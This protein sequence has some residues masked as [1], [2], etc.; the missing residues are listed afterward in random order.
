MLVNSL[1]LV[2]KNRGAGDPH[3]NPA[4]FPASLALPSEINV[5]WDVCHVLVPSRHLVTVSDS[6]C[7]NSFT[8]QQRLPCSRTP[9]GKIRLS[10]ATQAPS[11]PARSQAALTPRLHRL[12]RRKAAAPPRAIYNPPV[13]RHLPRPPQDRR[14]DW[15]PSGRD[16]TGAMPRW[17]TLT[18][19]A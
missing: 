12:R 4:A 9:Q 3:P 6:S 8:N 10:A 7:S 1:H 15:L 13:S 11:R 14:W 18:R 2:V 17:H 16:G 19:F 5:P